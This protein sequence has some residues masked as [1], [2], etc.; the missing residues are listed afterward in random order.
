MNFI[1]ILPIT[2]AVLA[3]LAAAF[4][5]PA[6]EV[7]VT[8]G[9]TKLYLWSYNGRDKSCYGL[10]SD[11][12]GFQQDAEELRI[13]VAE[14]RK[15]MVAVD[16]DTLVSMFDLEVTHREEDQWKKAEE[17]CLQLIEIEKKTLANQNFG[18]ARDKDS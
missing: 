3:V 11:E 5:I 4:Y 15:S 18:S 17:L 14:A 2:V 10:V 9:P 16:P 13:Q 8:Q 7:T 12:S 1:V 6:K